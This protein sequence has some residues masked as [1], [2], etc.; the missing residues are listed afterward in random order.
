MIAHRLSTIK[1]SSSIIAFHK[2]RVVEKG[3]HDELL[4]QEGSLYR[5]LWNKQCG[6]RNEEEVDDDLIVEEEEEMAEQTP[7]EAGMNPT[8]SALTRLECVVM[9]LP[10]S[11]PKKK[12]LQVILETLD[13]EA[14]LLAK[15]KHGRPIPQ[16]GI[17]RT[18][19]DQ[20]KWKHRMSQST[21]NGGPKSSLKNKPAN[22]VIFQEARAVRIARKKLESLGHG[23]E[24]LLP[25]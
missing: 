20:S 9:D 12:E 1:N 24:S 14:R 5:K 3:T 25:E 7:V 22:K 2:G 4:K 6:T 8:P 21:P 19:V 15:E 10:E 13:A 23:F 16:R 17:Q 18:S 11:D